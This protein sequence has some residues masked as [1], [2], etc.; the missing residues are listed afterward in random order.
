[1]IN[2]TT[3]VAI[4]VAIST[5]GLALKAVVNAFIIPSPALRLVNK[6]LND[7]TSP[8]IRPPILK[9]AKPAPIPAMT[10]TITAPLSLIKLKKV[11]TAGK[12]S[13]KI[14]ISISV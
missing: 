11:L 9:T 7:P 10:E 12:A 6:A 5:K 4:T 14:G 2:A 1:M 13:S 8:A 3:K